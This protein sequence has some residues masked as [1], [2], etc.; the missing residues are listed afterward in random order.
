M[1]LFQF[2]RHRLAISAVLSCLSLAAC[3]GGGDGSAGNGGAIS[4]VINLSSAVQSAHLAKYAGTFGVLSGPG[5]AAIYTSI[6]QSLV[7]SVT[8][9]T[10]S[11]SASC[12]TGGSIS[13]IAQGAGANGLQSGE[14]AT[15]TFN[16]CVGQVKAPGVDDSSLVSGT[17]SISI[18][19]VTGT[20]GSTTQNWSYSGTETANPLTLAAS[21]GTT[22]V[23]GTVA[24]TMSYNAATGVTTTTASSP[25]VTI[26]RAQTTA[27]NDI[28]GT[29]TVTSMTYSR[30]V[31]SK[32]ASDTLS[33]G[34]VVTVDAAGA[35]LA[36][37]VATPNPVTVSGST[38]TAGVITLTTADT[39]ETIT[40][41]NGSQVN[42]TV[43]ANGQTGS[44]TETEADFQGFI[45]A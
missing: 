36:F 23:A 4:S 21:N 19:N 41:T 28:N 18:Q 22:S 3:G 25:T 6:V 9:G 40:A 16:Q 33:T 13:V 34:G 24:F 17:A 32:P 1:K 31:G 29:I 8:S 11:R 14:T 38:V 5:T 44:Y 43:N 20:V 7:S 42:I 10:A 35:T 39:V 26:T 2:P 27:T 15:V 45:G 30:A 37:T 12:P